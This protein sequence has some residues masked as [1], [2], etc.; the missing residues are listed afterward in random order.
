[1][2][3]LALP[4]TAEP[5]DLGAS[6]LVIHRFLSLILES[7]APISQL[8]LVQ[9]LSLSQ[10]ADK[11]DCQVIGK[12]VATHLTTLAGRNPW[13]ALTVASDRD[14]IELAR[15][16]L[17]HCDPGSLLPYY[18]F[19]EKLSALKVNWQIH[20]LQCL[21][22]G[23]PTFEGIPRVKPPPPSTRSGRKI[24]AKTT[25]TPKTFKWKGAANLMEAAKIF[26]PPKR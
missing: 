15:P 5:I 6:V 8:D 3:D 18:G 2:R 19:W 9:T 25:F 21:F 13:E 14:D 20:L 24:P 22:P 16:T 7:N 10:L 11:Y 26:D 12:R 1:M 17:S 23:P 4:E